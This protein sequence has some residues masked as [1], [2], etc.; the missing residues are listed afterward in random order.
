SSFPSRGR[1]HSVIATGNG[2]TAAA[3]SSPY[4]HGHTHSP[5][6]E[7]HTHQRFSP[8]MTIS[9]TVA[10]LRTSSTS[11]P[12][13]TTSSSSSHAPSHHHPHPPRTFGAGNTHTPTITT[14][15]RSTRAQSVF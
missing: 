4:T 14:T 5:S 9:D 1:F 11:P 8:L 13:T 7:Q 12:L 10:D 15:G 2:V 3:A 6:P